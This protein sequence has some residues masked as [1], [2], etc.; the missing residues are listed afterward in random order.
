MSQN[1]FGTQQTLMVGG[2]AVQIFSL[3]TLA[4]SGYPTVD[5]L[6]YSLKILLENMLRREDGQSVTKED[7]ESSE[8]VP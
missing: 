5:R 8:T 7:I 1:S 4:E 6:P 3:R 2:E